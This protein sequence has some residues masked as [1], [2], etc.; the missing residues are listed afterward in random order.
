MWGWLME[1]KDLIG[2]T[3][4]LPITGRETSINADDYV[5]QTFGTG[6]V[7]IT[8]AHDPNDFEQGTVMTSNV[9]RLSTSMAQ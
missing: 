9:F 3:V 5:D 7:K 4:V 2:K 1:Y 8:P 6:A